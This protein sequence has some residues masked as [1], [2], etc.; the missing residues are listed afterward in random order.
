MFCEA[1]FCDLP[2]AS[3]FEIFV[4]GE[5]FYF[6]ADIQ[7]LVSFVVDIKQSGDFPIDIQQADTFVFDINQSGGFNLD[8][9]QEKLFTSSIIRWGVKYG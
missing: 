5:I 6:D 2:F 3:I 7:Q 8:I 4:N 1:P 9:Q